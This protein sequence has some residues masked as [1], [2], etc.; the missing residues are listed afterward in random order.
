MWKDTSQERLRR[1]Q[2][3]LKASPRFYETANAVHEK[4]PEGY[5]SR[6]IEAVGQRDTINV[7]C[8]YVLSP[9]LNS[10]V[11]WVLQEALQSGKKDYTFSPGTDT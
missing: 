5:T 9:V 3:I 8:D 11:L 10:Y 2:N 6:F 4:K 7:V 1:Y